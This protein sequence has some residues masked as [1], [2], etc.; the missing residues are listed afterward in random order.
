MSEVA[1]EGG[2]RAQVRQQPKAVTAD[3]RKL[4]VSK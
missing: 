3:A 4:Q 1:L 2:D